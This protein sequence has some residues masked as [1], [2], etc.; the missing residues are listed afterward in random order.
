MSQSVSQFHGP[1]RAHPSTGSQSGSLSTLGHDLAPPLATLRYGAAHCATAR[2][3]GRGGGGRR[4]TRRAAPTPRTPRAAP[5]PP[6]AT[7]RYGAARAAGGL[8]EGPPQPRRLFPQDPK[9]GATCGYGAAKVLK[10]SEAPLPTR[11]Q[12]DSDLDRLPEFNRG[13]ERRAAPQC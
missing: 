13:T 6:L 2:P 5:A 3:R 12:T 7:L 11:K 9:G 10:R 8:P 1:S 4:P